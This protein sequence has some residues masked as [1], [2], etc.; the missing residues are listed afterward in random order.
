MLKK[1][2]YVLG[3][4]AVL[5]LVLGWQNFSYDLV[6]L[7]KDQHRQMNCAQKNDTGLVYQT[8]TVVKIIV[9][10][11]LD[12]VVIFSGNSDGKENKTERLQKLLAENDVVYSE[13]KDNFD[14]ENFKELLSKV[15]ANKPGMYV[16]SA[17]FDGKNDLTD[18]LESIG[19]KV[20][21]ILLND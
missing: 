1:S 16:V 5:V 10:D 11:K 21:V 3:A 13:I 19:S 17:D 20:P 2:L 9:G 8:E 6:F 18:I 7:L 15:A 4:A 12:N 14:D